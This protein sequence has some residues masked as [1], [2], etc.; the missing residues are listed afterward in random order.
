MIDD[1]EFRTVHLYS[2]VKMQYLSVRLFGFHIM[3]RCQPG[4][5]GEIPLSGISAG[6]AGGS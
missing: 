4:N 5:G 6:K 1:T 3:L 2:L